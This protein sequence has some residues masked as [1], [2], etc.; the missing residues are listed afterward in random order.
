MLP[1]SKG[2][3]NEYA[4]SQKVIMPKEGQLILFPSW[5]I[6]SVPQHL[7]NEDRVNIA[8]NIS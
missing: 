6:H 5:M 2:E 1:I 4:E 3:Y 8:F 7:D